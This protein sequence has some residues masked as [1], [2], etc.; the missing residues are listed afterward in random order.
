LKYNHDEN[1]ALAVVLAVQKL[2]HYILVRTTKVIA[3]S[4]PIQYL[5]NRW[6]INDKFSW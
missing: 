4:N 3:D 2:W 6:Q 5:L 1:M